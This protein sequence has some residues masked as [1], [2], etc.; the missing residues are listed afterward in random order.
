MITFDEAMTFIN[1]FDRLGKPITDLNRMF[2]LLSL[3]GDPQNDLK[4]I[5]IAGTNGKGSV[6]QMC[7][8]ILVKAGYQ[9]GLFTSPYIVEYADRIKYN[10]Q[11]ISHNNLCKIVEY[12]KTIVDNLE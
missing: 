9:V 12:V 4:C 3:L 8:E 2:S 1:S 5:H 6:A 7:S 10:N 11:N